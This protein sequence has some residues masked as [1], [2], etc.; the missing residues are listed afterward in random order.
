[1]FYIIAIIDIMIY[2]TNV[3]EA[4]RNKTQKDYRRGYIIYC[5]AILMTIIFL[6]FI[7]NEANKTNNYV[8]NLEE[9]LN[10]YR[11]SYEEFCLE[12]SLRQSDVYGQ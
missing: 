10:I 5:I 11:E 9:K 8:Q 1:M 4:I 12:D 2:L 7:H 6:I 3:I